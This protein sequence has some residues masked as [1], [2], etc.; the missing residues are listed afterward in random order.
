MQPLSVASPKPHQ[1]RVMICYWK[2]VTK[3]RNKDGAQANR[4]F[5]VQHRCV[6]GACIYN[7]ECVQSNSFC[8]DTIQIQKC[9]HVHTQINPQ[10]GIHTHSSCF[11]SYGIARAASVGKINTCTANA[12]RKL[13]GANKNIKCDKTLVTLIYMSSLEQYLVFNLSFCHYCQDSSQR[14][15]AISP[16][17]TNTFNS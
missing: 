8:K 2:L 15:W 12:S 13:L 14:A 4:F 16:D 6:K 7:C 1:W 3:P 5:S 17:S 11:C 10:Q 9:P